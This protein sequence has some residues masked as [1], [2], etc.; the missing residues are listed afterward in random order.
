MPV[1]KTE[2]LAEVQAAG[3]LVTAKEAERWSKAV[4]T[5]LT[6]LAPDSETRRHFI[7]QLP[8][9]LKA[10]LLDETPRALLMDRDALLQRVGAA[11]GTHVVEAERAVACVWSVLRRAV[12]AGEIADFQARVPSDIASYLARVA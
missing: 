7:T 8:G 12:S 5:A 1:K 9:F 11:L 3:A 2:F 4:L 10:P 6:E